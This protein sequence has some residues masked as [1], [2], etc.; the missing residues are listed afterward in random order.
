MLQL[1]NLSAGVYILK[2]RNNEGVLQT[3]IVKF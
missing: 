2:L 3:K 1:E